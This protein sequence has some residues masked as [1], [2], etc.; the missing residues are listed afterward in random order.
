MFQPS[1]PCRRMSSKRLHWNATKHSDSHDGPLFS[2]PLALANRMELILH[3]LSTAVMSSTQC[4]PC[5]LMMPSDEFDR[6]ERIL[7]ALS[8]AVRS[9]TPCNPCDLMM[10]SDEFDDKERGLTTNALTYGLMPINDIDYHLI[11]Q[12]NCKDLSNPAWSVCIAYALFGSLVW[13]VLPSQA[14]STEGT[15]KVKP[16]KCLV[17]SLSGAVA[18][19]LQAYLTTTSMILSSRECI[20]KSLSHL[21]V[22][23]QLV[24]L[25]ARDK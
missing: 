14:R 24:P 8:T 11:E 6:M 12:G 21:L 9:S 23:C 2:L 19:A 20:E 22:C 15:A 10:P 25:S 18:C 5:D 1:R 4:K 13:L 3:V 17:T 16:H 7:Y